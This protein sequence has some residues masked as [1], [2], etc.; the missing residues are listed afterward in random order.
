LVVDEWQ[1]SLEVDHGPIGAV[2]VLNKEFS[3]LEEQLGV[4]SGHGAVVED[5]VAE[6]GSADAQLTGTVLVWIVS[7]GAEIQTE[8]CIEKTRRGVVTSDHHK[9]DVWAGMVDLCE[10]TEVRRGRGREK[11]RDR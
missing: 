7:S 2:S 9:R 11:E 8:L 3:I 5:H 6:R 4:D 1:G 10:R